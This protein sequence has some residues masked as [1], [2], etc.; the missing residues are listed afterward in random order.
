MG[1]AGEG[2]STF[3]LYLYKKLWSEFKV[4]SALPIF[5]ALPTIGKPDTELLHEHFRSKGFIAEEIE[6]LRT[7]HE[8]IFILDGYDEMSSTPNLYAS[9]Q[10]SEWRAKIII[11]CRS[12]YFAQGDD[13]LGYFAPIELG[14]MLY[15]TLQE[16]TTIP[17]NEQQIAAYVTKYVSNEADAQAFGDE[18]H[19]HQFLTI[20]QLN[21]LIITPFL[22]MMALKVI[23]AISRKYPNLTEVDTKKIAE[24][25]LYDEFMKWWF[26]R[27]VIKV[28]SNPNITI[29]RCCNLAGEF[30]KISTELAIEMRHA[31]V[32]QVHY[33]T[34]EEAL[35]NAYGRS[36]DVY[37]I[38][39]VTSAELK[40]VA[41]IENEMHL[42]YISD[43][44]DLKDRWRIVARN[45]ASSPT[46]NPK[47]GWLTVDELEHRWA[48]RKTNIVEHQE[49]VRQKARALTYAL[50]QLNQYT[51]ET[52]SAELN[53]TI[54]EAIVAGLTH[55]W[56]YFF[57]LRD[58]RVKRTLPGVPVQPTEHGG[59]MFIHAQV[60]N[61]FYTRAIKLEARPDMTGQGKRKPW[62]LA[63]A[64]PVAP[65]MAQH[66][67]FPTVPQVQPG[68]TIIYQT[69]VQQPP[70]ITPPPET[71][72]KSRCLIS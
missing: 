6:W 58:E 20:F 17:F 24:S 22:L 7:H 61:Y 46:Y 40:K 1:N 49:S 28:Q 45:N 64:V 21:E 5:I 16:V 60:L 59:Y 33:Q 2:K 51:P 72:K 65:A 54:F 67:I 35:G 29:P 27:G 19:Y 42:L 32:M 47:T 68:N 70:P 66:G 13:Y 3:N 62:D 56:D 34:S 53:N 30:K 44:Q 55:P 57:D 14:Q 71:P 23:P 69:I 63:P 37:E 8:F 10:L 41:L 36:F 43:C 26:M 12:Q 25:E 4:G 9:N 48:S 11:S 31:D 50:A 18:A 38:T 52:M 15:H 39:T